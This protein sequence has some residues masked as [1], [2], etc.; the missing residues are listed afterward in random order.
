MNLSG[1]QPTDYIEIK[2]GDSIEGYNVSQDLPNTIICEG[3]T[4]LTFKNCNLLNCKIPDDAK[5]DDCLHRQK[6]FCYH[7]Y[8]D[9]IKDTSTRPLLPVEEENCRHVTDIIELDGIV[10]EYRRKD[11]LIDE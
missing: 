11:R 5:I 10:I 3:L 8:Y 9:K 2:N 7:E 4:G 6:D 1:K